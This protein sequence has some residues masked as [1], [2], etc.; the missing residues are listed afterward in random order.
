MSHIHEKYDFVVNAFIVY[1]NQVLLVNHPRYDK[2][3]PVGGHIE[4]DEDPEEALFR[5]VREEVGLE[6]ELI[7]TKPALESPGTKFIHT[8]SFLDVHEAEPPHR[9]IALIY[10]AKAKNSNYVKSAEH[11]EVRWVSLNDLDEKDYQLSP[12]VK[13]YAEEAIKAAKSI[14]R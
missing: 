2:W 7:D 3:L 1:E 12:A 6:I 8:P 9:H 10:F 13:F 14:N 4:L 11:L 5:E